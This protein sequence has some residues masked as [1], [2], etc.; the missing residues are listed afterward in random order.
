MK[1]VWH[2]SSN[3]LLAAPPETPEVTE[4]HVTMEVQD[5]IPVI[6]SYWKPTAVELE[7][8]FDG[9]FVKLSCM[10]HT[11]PP[12]MLETSKWVEPKLEVHLRSHLS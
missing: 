2:P 11:M 1:A 5:D 7:Q 9:G 10:G 4:L 6:V 8:L 3:L 12:V